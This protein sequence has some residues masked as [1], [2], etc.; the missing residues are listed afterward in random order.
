MPSYVRNP[1]WA[2]GAGGGT[3]IAA[4]KLSSGS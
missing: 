2:D 4:A 1:T 3:A